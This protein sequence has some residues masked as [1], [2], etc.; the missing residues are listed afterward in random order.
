MLSACAHLLPDQAV[1]TRPPFESFAAAR[2]AV[3]RIAPFHTRIAELGAMGFD[4][5]GGRNAR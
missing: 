5:E 4:V 2:A 3:E 1:D